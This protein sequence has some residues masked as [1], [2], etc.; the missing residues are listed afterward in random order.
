M[1]WSFSSSE[2][3]YRRGNPTTSLIAQSLLAKSRPRHAWV[4][5]QRRFEQWT[6]PEWYFTAHG[7]EVGVEDFRVWVPPRVREIDGR[8]CECQGTRRF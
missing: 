1:R 7:I 2:G 4:C 5:Q 8:T 6:V 3:E